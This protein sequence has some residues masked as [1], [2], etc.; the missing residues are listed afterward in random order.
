MNH[1]DENTVRENI[2]LLGAQKTAKGAAK[3]G[4]SREGIS[5]NPHMKP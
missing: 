3:G 4:C 5:R 1:L 2:V